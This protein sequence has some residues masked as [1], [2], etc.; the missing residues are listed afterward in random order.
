LLGHYKNRPLIDA[1]DIYQHLLDYWAETMQDDAYLVAADG[2]KAETYRLVEMDKKGKPKDKGWACDLVP[3]PLIVARYFASEQTALDDLAAKL[4][5]ASARLAELEE[6]H[7]GEEGAFGDLEKVNKANV[8]SRMKEIR[9]D[10]EAAEESAI[11]KQWLDLNAEETDLKQRL[12]K[13]EG[14]L[15]A[16]AYARYPTLSEAE[17]KTLVVEDK[18]LATLDAR[19]HGEMDRVSQQLTARVRELAERYESTLPSLTDRVA[20]LEAKVNGHLE[21]MGFAFVRHERK[22]P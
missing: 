21:R 7:G 5:A 19:I 11:L 15:D 9:N 3:K 4:E 20:E 10:T 13:A 2:W 22:T 8:Q 18:W 14:E 1:Y 16:K 6:E 12:K 17:V